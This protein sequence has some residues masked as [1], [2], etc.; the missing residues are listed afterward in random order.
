MAEHAV[1]MA[2]GGPTGLMVAAELALADVDVVIVDR[3]ASRIPNAR[4]PAV[5]TRAPSRCSISAA[6]PPVSPGGEGDAD[7]GVWSN[8]PGHQ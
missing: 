2:G 4:P 3:R 7:P 6:S 1:V 8:P 5:C